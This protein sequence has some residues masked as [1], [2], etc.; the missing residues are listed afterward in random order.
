MLERKVF[1]HYRVLT[2]KSTEDA[3]RL[4][5]LVESLI[6]EQINAG[7]VGYEEFVIR[8]SDAEPF[9]AETLTFYV[10]NIEE[11]KSLNDWL[12]SIA[13]SKHT[14]NRRKYPFARN[15]VIY[16]FPNLFHTIQEDFFTAKN[17]DLFESLELVYFKCFNNESFY[18]FFTMFS[19]TTLT[20]IALHE[21][22]TSS[23]QFQQLLGHF[24]NLKE[25]TLNR[26]SMKI[27][28]TYNFAPVRTQL[29]TTRLRDFFATNAW[30]EEKRHLSN[31]PRAKRFE[32]N[33]HR[34]MN[35]IDI[36]SSIMPS[37]EFQYSEVSEFADHSYYNKPSTD[38]L[39]SLAEA[40]ISRCP[41]KIEL[42]I[43]M[44][45]DPFFYSLLFIADSK[46]STNLEA[47]RI[48]ITVPDLFKERF[49]TNRAALSAFTK[50]IEEAI[51]ASFIPKRTSKS[52]LV[53]LRKNSDTALL[54]RRAYA[55]IRRAFPD[56]KFD[57]ADT[58]G[59]E[60][61]ELF[62]PADLVPIFNN[63]QG[64]VS[65]A[66]PFAFSSVLSFLLPKTTRSTFLETKGL[67]HFSAKLQI[68]NE[69]VK[70]LSI[71]H[72][73]IHDLIHVIN[74]IT[75]MKSKNRQINM[76]I[77]APFILQ[78]LHLM[79][80]RDKIDFALELTKDTPASF[81]ISKIL[82]SVINVA[83]VRKTLLS[84]K[85]RNLQVA[86][87]KI[88]PP[89]TNTEY[90]LNNQRMFYSL[91]Y[92][93]AQ[94][95]PQSY[96]STD[97]LKQA[98]KLSFQG[99]MGYRYVVLRMLR[100]EVTSGIREVENIQ[101]L[102]LFFKQIK[103]L[104]R[105][106][107]HTS[108]EVNAILFYADFSKIMNDLISNTITKAECL[109]L[110]SEQAP[111][112]LPSN[113]A[114][115]RK[116]WLSQLSQGCYDILGQH[117]RE[118]ANKVNSTNHYLNLIT[119]ISD[120]PDLMALLDS[121]NRNTFAKVVGNFKC[122]AS[123]YS[124]LDSRSLS[125]ISQTESLI[126]D[127]L[128]QTGI[129]ECLADYICQNRISSLNEIT[130]A[131]IYSVLNYTFETAFKPTFSS[132]TWQE[133]INSLATRLLKDFQNHQK[134][135]TRAEN[136]VEFLF[137][138][139]PM[140]SFAA[141]S[142][143]R[144]PANMLKKKPKKTK[145]ALSNQITQQNERKNEQKNNGAPASALMSSDGSSYI[146]NGPS[147]LS[148]LYSLDE[149]NSVTL[150]ESAHNLNSAKLT[151]LLAHSFLH[152]ALS[153]SFS[154][155]LSLI[156]HLWNASLQFSLPAPSSLPSSSSPS[157][158]S[159]SSLSSS[160]SSLQA[161][162]H[163]ASFFANRN[164]TENS[165]LDIIFGKTL[166]CIQMEMKNLN[167][168]EKKSFGY[169]E[170]DVEI[171]DDPLGFLDNPTDDDFTILT[172][173]TL[174]NRQLYE[175]KLQDQFTSQDCTLVVT[176]ILVGANKVATK[177]VDILNHE[178]TVI[179]NGEFKGMGIMHLAVCFNP[180]IANYKLAEFIEI[181][182]QKKDV[183]NDDGRYAG[184]N[185]LMLACAFGQT[186][187]ISSILVKLSEGS[188]GF[189][190]RYFAEPIKNN[191]L[192]NGYTA[193]LLTIENSN[194][195]ADFEALLY[196]FNHIGISA[197]AFKTAAVIKESGI[198][199][200]YLA[201]KHAQLSVLKPLIKRLPLMAEE[202]KGFHPMRGLLERDPS[203]AGF[204]E[205]GEFL[206]ACYE[207][208]LNN[209]RNLSA[210]TQKLM[211]MAIERFDHAVMQAAETLTSPRMRIK[212]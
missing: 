71:D 58:Q 177:L 182:L 111:L 28:E 210:D 73:T 169:E 27:L 120:V 134:K 7:S 25:M 5:P 143:K 56:I 53:H 70:L 13:K 208:T 90:D 135:I 144:K 78:C 154:N 41:K 197:L 167:H 88:L 157:L 108:F 136:N 98:L 23:Y 137:T 49:G 202:Y 95:D 97:I 85:S 47:L 11:L 69:T 40:I 161:L 203:S 50:K 148:S 74:R 100:I 35:L 205:I 207:E 79:I 89:T 102:M 84:I 151:N 76:A 17:V 52:F 36:L 129:N 61:H 146:Q 191:S 173:K 24:S 188:Q 175:F 105:V 181:I 176:A 140:K 65:S 153:L 195:F 113:L 133:L 87:F 158:P 55:D 165:P 82:N 26:F 121:Q 199:A 64:N 33:H 178:D 171:V 159:S 155:F 107:A 126:R 83:W 51:N 184:Y 138:N 3:Q 192:K 164:D 31:D 2:I 75:D 139:N 42:P 185:F 20:K 91:R 81:S 110:L 19:P 106:D 118:A 209:P 174:S 96:Y 116:E 15:L 37:H 30:L 119:A 72:E 103:E 168:D 34:K 80:S 9:H 94:M 180:F 196:L 68:R 114:V 152:P 92:L 14:E 204:R 189:R 190:S 45:L 93:I 187:L 194:K 123:D 46:F 1:D 112:T 172:D 198:N 77:F 8:A 183:L 101:E 130:I 128:Q 16:T 60:N 54:E 206:R 59:K 170:D 4:F 212:R 99:Q 125:K 160:S 163:R 115:E 162:S 57:L 18:N 122:S 66:I 145:K 147:P 156:S 44:M 63:R 48:H 186:Q 149:K 10:T 86:E 109:R 117:A 166:R 141:S 22:S 201:A 32:H 142:K 150:R 211:Q 179:N 131:T 29:R 200:L 62:H 6:N 193:L 12:T 132:A 39:S 67:A 38:D 124:H 104:I 43:S 127:F 21:G